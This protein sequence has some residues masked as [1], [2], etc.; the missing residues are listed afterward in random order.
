MRSAGSIEQNE[1]A[2]VNF[3]SAFTVHFTNFMG[4]LLVVKQWLSGTDQRHYHHPA[5]NKDRF[6]LQSLA[7]LAG[8]WFLQLRGGEE[9]PIITG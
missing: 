9:E 8:R 4:Q 6:L 2:I 1:A 5:N 3:S 7:I